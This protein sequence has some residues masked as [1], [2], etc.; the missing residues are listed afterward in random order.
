MDKID[1]KSDFDGRIANNAARKAVD[2]Y[3]PPIATVEKM[4]ADQILAST[5]YE[6]IANISY[7]EPRARIFYE[8][9]CSEKTVRELSISIHQDGKL[10]SKH[11]PSQWKYVPPETNGARL[12][13]L[14]CRER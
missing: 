9:N 6:E 14:V 1:V 3:I 10:G 13:A 4:D 12:L 5:I 8:L 7:I 11:E 2:G